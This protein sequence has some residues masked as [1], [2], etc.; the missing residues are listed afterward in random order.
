MLLSLSLRSNTSPALLIGDGRK[1]QVIQKE[2]MRPVCGAI[3]TIWPL[4]FWRSSVS[5]Q[6]KP[7]QKRRHLAN[8]EIGDATTVRHFGQGTCGSVGACKERT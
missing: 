2:S 6:W 3:T 7:A 5:I 8:R 1:Y 4:V